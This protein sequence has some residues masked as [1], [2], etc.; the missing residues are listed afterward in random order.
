[1]TG[2]VAILGGGV[3]GGSLALRLAR[4]GRHVT[5]IE[6]RAFPRVKVCGEYLSPASARELHELL[7]E[8]ALEALGARRASSFALELDDRAIE[9]PTPTATWSLSRSTLDTELVRLAHEAGATVLQPE[10]VRRADLAAEGARISLASGREIF[11]ELVVHADG[12]GRFDPA[13][14]TPTIDGLVGLKCHYRPEGPVAGVRIRVAE[15][16]Y[17]GTIAIEHGGATLALCARAEL[18]RQ[19]GGDHDALVRARWPAW[20]AARRSSDWLACGVARSWP[21]APAHPRS[22]RIGNARAAVD[23]VGGEG[24]G[25]ALWSAA[26][27]CEALREL[28]WR[29]AGALSRAQRT[30]HNQYRARLRTR[31]PACRWAA[32]LAMSPRLVRA[33]WPLL[34]ATRPFT[35]GAWYRLMGKPA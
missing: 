22:L 10:A 35:F 23:P 13:G 27:A 25:L 26:R 19:F 2:G 24:M 1:M 9:W 31:L 5:L 20:S 28:D 8:P 32:E 17:L 6:S 29:D 4:A 21:I 33:A 30:L 34:C 12:S 18:V 7:P 3:A 14:P 16:A 15:G 11:A